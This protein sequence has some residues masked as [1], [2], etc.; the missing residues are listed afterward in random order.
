M[1]VH[2]GKEGFTLLEIIVILAILAIV[3]ALVLPNFTSALQKSNA[4]ALKGQ[5]EKLKEACLAFNID[6]GGWPVEYS[7]DPGKSQL[8]R[9]VPPVPLWNGPYLSRPLVTNP[10]GGVVRIRS[11]SQQH[12]FVAGLPVANPCYLEYT[13]VP[14]EVCQEI[15]RELDGALGA[16][17]GVVIYAS[18]AL[19]ILIV[20]NAVAALAP[21]PPTVTTQEAT[22][23]GTSCATL[24][25]HYD[26]KDYGSGQVR[27]AYKKSLAP[28]WSYTSWVDKSGSGPYS[29]TISGL[30]S[31]T[32][33]QFKAQLRYDSTVIEGSVKSFTTGALAPTVR[34]DSA[35]DITISS[36]TLHGTLLD[37]GSAPSVRVS[38]IWGTSP[39]ALTQETTPQTLTS[40]GPFSASLSGLCSNTTYYFR[41]K[42]VGDGTAYGTI[43]SFTTLKVPPT[44]TTQE[45][46]NIGTS[47][48]TL[49][50]HYD[51]KDYGS[52]QVRFAYKKSLAPSWS[53]TSWVDK[54]GSGPYSETIS[55]LC[56]NTTYQFKAQLKYDSTMIEGSVKSFVTLKKKAS[57]KTESVKGWYWFYCWNGYWYGRI[58]VTARI[59]YGDYNSVQVRIRYRKQGGPW[60]YTRC[61]TSSSTHYVKRIWGWWKAGATYEFE[62][63][64]RFDSQYAY[65]GIKS[66]Q[67]PGPLHWVPNP[68]WLLDH[69][70]HCPGEG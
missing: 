17:E 40:T 37:L 6:T 4:I 14:D 62:A 64:I 61:E 11:D 45:A 34:T 47:C 27:F 5:F 53:Y 26:F 65:G 3:A 1:K 16:T 42:A 60:H 39:G 57:V 18:G 43:K 63:M 49:N 12:F 52:G 13:K 50:M 20:G 28:S 29:E 32:T 35:T 21:L 23:I 66:L 58:K 68:R 59:D 36:A 67:V 10:W 69:G 46:T 41:A 48:A 56:S 30:C 31:N 7:D 54:S 55:G 2:Q 38:F 15:D 9:N 51:F 22:N 8:V 33:Y 44:V 24:N 19:R 25:M 70:L